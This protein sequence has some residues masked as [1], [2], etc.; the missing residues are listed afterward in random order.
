MESVQQFAGNRRD[1]VFLQL[2]LPAKEN[3]QDVVLSTEEKNRLELFLFKIYTPS[4]NGA[5]PLEQF[6]T[7]DEDELDWMPESS[8]Y[9]LRTIHNRTSIAGTEA[10]TLLYIAGCRLLSSASVG[11]CRASATLEHF[12]I[13]EF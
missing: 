5:E 3:L 7:G 6:F 13:K 11:G 2:S 9:A 1:P 12:F 4:Y 10:F 8:R